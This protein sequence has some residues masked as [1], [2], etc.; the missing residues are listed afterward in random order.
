MGQNV[1]QPNLELGVGG[2]V[3]CYT[4]PYCCSMLLN[5]DLKSYDP[6]VNCSVIFTGVCDVY[7]KKLGNVETELRKFLASYWRER[8]NI[9]GGATCVLQ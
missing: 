5:F 3:N 4:F 1:Y 8:E 6:E 9:V 7:G 2:G